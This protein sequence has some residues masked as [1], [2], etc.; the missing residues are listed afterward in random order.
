MAYLPFC[1]NYLAPRPAFIYARFFV[2]KSY[3][4]KH[5]EPGNKK[6][7]IPIVIGA[8]IPIGF[9]LWW[10]DDHYDDYLEDLQEKEKLGQ[11]GG[12]AKDAEM[13]KEE[14]KDEEE[15]RSRGSS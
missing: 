7:F 11:T 10:T 15:W 6:N 14:K 1:S 8:L 2:A 4:P 9:L 13:L 12:V 5:P 3:K